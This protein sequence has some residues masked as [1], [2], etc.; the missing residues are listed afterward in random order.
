MVEGLFVLDDVKKKKKKEDRI[1]PLLKATISPTML[2]RGISSRKN[3]IAMVI[4]TK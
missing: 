3:L 2:M 4:S 1:N